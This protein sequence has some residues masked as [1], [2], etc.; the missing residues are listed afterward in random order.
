MQPYLSAGL[1]IRQTHAQIK[2]TAPGVPDIY[3]GSEALDFSL[4]D[5]DNRREPDFATLQQQLSTADAPDFK[6]QADWLNGRLKQQVIARILHLRLD[7]PQLFRFG[8][9]QALYATGD[10]AEHVI[11]YARQDSNDTLLV[12]V[13]RLLLDGQGWAQ[14]V[15]QLP[16]SLAHRRYRNLLSGEMISLN[17]QLSLANMPY[18]A[19]LVLIA[20]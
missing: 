2:L 18:Y 6:Q 12:V 10:N 1:I 4:V 3:Q 20:S 5:P 8:D 9:Y 19:P 14:A 15:I 11:A 13:P 16:E 7:K 17:Q